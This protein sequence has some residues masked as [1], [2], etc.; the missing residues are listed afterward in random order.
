MKIKQYIYDSVK[1]IIGDFEYK[2]IFLNSIEK[3]LVYLLETKD[4]KF[5]LKIKNKSYDPVGEMKKEVYGRKKLDHIFKISKIKNY[6]ITKVI[7]YNLKD[8]WVLFEY[9]E[10]ETLYE[11]RKRDNERFR[12]VL[13]K[14]YNDVLFKLIKNIKLTQK[15]PGDYSYNDIG[16]NN[17]VFYFFDMEKSKSLLQN[18]VDMYTK[19]VAIYYRLKDKEDAKFIED[20]IGTIK[21][22]QEKYLNKKSFNYYFLKRLKS[23]T[24]QDL[25]VGFDVRK[26]Y[27]SFKY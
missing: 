17:G 23:S 1:K 20:L 19:L 25:L 4:K 15:V 10:F 16:H 8:L 3:N 27:I 2:L 22:M 21:N 11:I 7:S 5:V 12:N 24:L 14:F 9:S 6:F 18:I 13:I 26:V